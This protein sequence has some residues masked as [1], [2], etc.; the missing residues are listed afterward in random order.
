MNLKQWIPSP[1]RERWRPRYQRNRK[2]LQREGRAF[3]EATVL[4]T[5]KPWK[6]TRKRL[7]GIT[8]SEEL[9]KVAHDEFGI[10]QVQSEIS[11]FLD[12]IASQQ[13]VVIGE[14]GLKHG[15]NSFLFL[16]K[17]AKTELYLGMDLVL[18]NTAK[19]RYYRRRGQKL[20]FFEGNSQ[21]P[22][23][24]ACAKKALRG[25]PFDFLFIDG[26]HSYRG[27]LEDL[28][29]WYPLVR[30]GGLIAFHDIVPDIEAKT[31]VRPEGTMIWGGGVYKLWEA[32]RPHFSA[33]EFVEDWDQGGFGIGV[34]EKPAEDQL[35]PALIAQLRKADPEPAVEAG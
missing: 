18:E 19:L 7:D 17:L 27:V 33:R 12:Y 9:Y 5:P 3:L 11:S 29:Q 8:G 1:L 13:P 28:I 16:R 14:I 22:R 35:A 21:L 10:L 25:R 24:V 20:H 30:P 32:L 6:A 34:M 23:M 4:P 26:D 31:G 2:W 15:G